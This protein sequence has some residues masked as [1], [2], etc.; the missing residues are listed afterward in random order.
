MNTNPSHQ[1]SDQT[2]QRAEETLQDLHIDQGRVRSEI[3]L[4]MAPTGEESTSSASTIIA[5]LTPLL[6]L[7]EGEFRALWTH[8]MLNLLASREENNPTKQSESLKLISFLSS[9]L[10]CNA[11]FAIDSLNP[12]L[13]S[14]KRCSVTNEDVVSEIINLPTSAWKFSLS[15]NERGSSVIRRFVAMSSQSFDDS[16]T[17]FEFQITTDCLSLKDDPTSLTLQVFRIDDS[18]KGLRDALEDFTGPGVEM[19]F[20]LLSFRLQHEINNVSSAQDEEPL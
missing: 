19:L 7:S 9:G 20:N 17:G 13:E 10:T 4:L 3:D 6:P 5:T 12:E 11:L 14:L 8:G 15:L 2:H 1:R 16:G 18:Y